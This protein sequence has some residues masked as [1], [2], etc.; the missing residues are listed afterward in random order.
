MSC[1]LSSYIPYS[2]TTCPLRLGILMPSL[3]HP[4]SALVRSNFYSDSLFSR[5]ASLWPRLLA[6]CFPDHDNL[7]SLQVQSEALSFPHNPIKY[8]CW[9]FSCNITSLPWVD[10]G[11]FIRGILVYK[12]IRTVSTFSVI[13]VKLI[14]NTVFVET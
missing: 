4:H 1:L 11:P 7:Q 5:N 6:W 2:Q 10:L 14:H 9:R 12:A 13:T 8:T 3:N